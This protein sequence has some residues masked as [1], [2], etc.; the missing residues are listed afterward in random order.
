MLQREACHCISLSYHLFS[1]CRRTDLSRE[2]YAARTPCAELWCRNIQRD[3]E[4]RFIG[5]LG[6]SL[7]CTSYAILPLGQLQQAH[8]SVRSIRSRK[9]VWCDCLAQLRQSGKIR[10]HTRLKRYYLLP[11]TRR[12]EEAP[13][14]ENLAPEPYYACPPGH[15]ASAAFHGERDWRRS[16]FQVRSHLTSAVFH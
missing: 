7:N 5:Y 13:T 1:N 4:A 3:D 2:C 11:S 14:T 9:I 16:D 10:D 8:R 12:V 15:R 6:H